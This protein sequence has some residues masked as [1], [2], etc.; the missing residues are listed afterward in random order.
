MI[1][2]EEIRAAIDVFIELGNENV[3]FAEVMKEYHSVG[4]T[5]AFI[6][7]D[8]GNAGF[9]IDGGKLKRVDEIQNP[10]VVVS[11]DKATFT[12]MCESIAD[13][14]NPAEAVDLQLSLAFWTWRTLQISG[15]NW[16]AEAKNLRIIILA[17]VQAMIGGK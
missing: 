8:A 3:D 9:V 4:K 17:L 13:S 14:P 5:L 7:R 12:V 10:T 11:L 6:I 2:D 15:T 1:E 16:Y